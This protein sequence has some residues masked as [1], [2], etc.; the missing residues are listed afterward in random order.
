MLVL[1]HTCSRFRQ[2]AW[3]L[4][5]SCCA[6]AC[7]VWISV[8]CWSWATFQV[9]ALTHKCHLSLVKGLDTIRCARVDCSA[10][11]ALLQ[12]TSIIPS[13]GRPG[14]R[15]RTPLFFLPCATRPQHS[16][17]GA[18]GSWASWCETKGNCQCSLT[19]PQQQV[20]SLLPPVLSS[21]SELDVCNGTVW[22]DGPPPPPPTVVLGLL[23][24]Y[25]EHCWIPRPSTGR[26]G[27]H[28][29][30]HQ[31]HVVMYFGRVGE[32]SPWSSAEMGSVEA[33]NRNTKL[34]LNGYVC[35]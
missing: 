9:F 14:K 10:L 18:L 35:R 22:H 26:V 3:L 32:S 1:E 6:A 13:I 27:N 17:A 21:C 30:T 16:P 34:G 23:F 20:P 19:L 4:H 12:S 11:A 25:T 33:C 28:M 31:L 24:F 8:L 15:R 29:C 2:G 7:V 5:V